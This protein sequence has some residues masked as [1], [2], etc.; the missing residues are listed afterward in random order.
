MDQ[1]D[2]LD[3]R[4][5]G[6]GDKQPDRA[7]NEPRAPEGT[8][9]RQVQD[10]KESL[11]VLKSQ[12]SFANQC[13]NLLQNQMKHAADTLNI[14]QDQ[15]NVAQ[16]TVNNLTEGGESQQHIIT[17]HQ[18][19]AALAGIGSYQVPSSRVSCV[20]G[21]MEEQRVIVHDSEGPKIY[22]I[23]KSSISL[24]NQNVLAGE[25]GI[26]KE[27]CPG[28]CVAQTLPVHC[29]C[30]A[31][32]S[33]ASLQ[34]LSPQFHTQNQG[35]PRTSVHQV[36]SEVL[37]SQSTCT[38]PGQLGR[39]GVAAVQPNMPGPPAHVPVS[40]E[41]SKEG[42][43]S[44]KTAVK[45]ESASSSPMAH[46][47]LQV[48][49]VLQTADDD[50]NKSAVI[51]S[52]SLSSHIPGGYAIKGD[53]HAYEMGTAVQH[54]PSRRNRKQNISPLKPSMQ[55]SVQDV[56]SPGKLIVNVAMFVNV[57]YTVA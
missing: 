57:T 21:P 43:D 15:I 30:T 37:L 46:Q 33:H 52:C 29:H 27:N 16:R 38:S 1:R 6:S 2:N 8:L 13:F 34:H 3:N 22:T 14:L 39:D 26:V 51:S 54:R 53:V 25:G 50:D 36:S 24:G 47:L 56:R 45:S 28:M 18:S 11:S 40:P 20:A 7:V 44:R 5:S 42:C 49:D 48:I 32:L 12:V 35:H 23:S 19:T 55:S 31:C 41:C 9:L 10:T 17:H 4:L